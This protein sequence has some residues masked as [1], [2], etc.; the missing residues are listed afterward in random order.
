[1][2]SSIVEENRRISR[3]IQALIGW[4]FWDPFA[5]K[6][7]EALGVPGRVGYMTRAAP[8]AAAGDDAII[9]AFSTIHPKIVR[10]MLGAIRAATTFET[11]WAARDQ[12]VVEGLRTYLTAGQCDALAAQR[13]AL[14]RAV[15][16][17]PVPGRTF[18]AAHLALERPDDPLLSAWHGANGVREWRADTHM[19]IL[20]SEGLDA[21]EASILHSAWMGYPHDWVPASRGWNGE[22]L[23]AGFESLEAKGLADAASATVNNEGIALREHIEQR[24][25]EL[26]CVPWAAIGLDATRAIADAL[27]PI[28][29]VLLKRVD[30]TVGQYWMPAA[31]G[32]HPYG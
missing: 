9:G 5:E 29:P 3:L 19:A 27:E 24:T 32:R 14:W 4:I 31:R 28:A 12:A 22:E 30:D 17:C 26:S 16:A 11:M 1:M 2:D 23:A 6:R 7:Y 10:G 20:V 25:D 15:E 18:F 21:A 8:L 13:E